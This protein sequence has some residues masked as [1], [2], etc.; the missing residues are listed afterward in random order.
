MDKNRHRVWF[1]LLATAWVAATPIAG[2]FWYWCEGCAGFCPAPITAM[3]CMGM[4]ILSAPTQA[5]VW[6]LSFDEIMGF[7]ILNL[8]GRTMLSQAIVVGLTIYAGLISLR[9]A[10]RGVRW[11]V[12]RIVYHRG[13]C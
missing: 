7:D 4:W 3:M 5:A 11:V 2:V 10:W 8:V 12:G 9:H 13:V 6:V 1:A